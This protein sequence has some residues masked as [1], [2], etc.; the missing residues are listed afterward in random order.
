MSLINEA[1]KRARQ[2]QTQQTVQVVEPPLEPVVK[3]A[4]HRDPPQWLTPA[5]SLGLLFVGLWFIAL[6]WRSSES[7]A[8]PAQAQEPVADSNQTAMAI[9]AQFAGK[10]GHTGPAAPAPVFVGSYGSP[11]AGQAVTPAVQRPQPAPAPTPDARASTPSAVTQA[12]AE[13]SAQPTATPDLK[14]ADA[15]QKTADDPT[16]AFRVQGIFFRLN[17]AST[18]INNQ[19][20]F[21]GDEIEGAKIVGIERHSV[22]L[23]I[24]GQTHTLRLR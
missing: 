23:K 19:T 22:Q 12:R 14:P 16:A 8:T 17:K 5:A 3:S 20:L 2:A 10:I 9:A 6:W 24:A 1:L 11:G 13:A 21:V 7:E 18:L 15:S 4:S